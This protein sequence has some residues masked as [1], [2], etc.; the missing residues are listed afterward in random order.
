MTSNANNIRTILPKSNREAAHSPPRHRAKLSLPDSPLSVITEPQ[1]SSSLPQSELIS[2]TLKENET[3]DDSSLI[4]ARST[5]SPEKSDPRVIKQR[6]FSTKT[7]YRSN[8][9]MTPSRSSEQTNID[10]LHSPS[11]QSTLIP[12]MIIANVSRRSSSSS[13]SSSFDETKIIGRRR[14]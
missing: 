6:L 14:I 2:T 9:G 7:I 8:S 11:T 12:F 4:S 13:S 10:A 3:A 1:L 5:K